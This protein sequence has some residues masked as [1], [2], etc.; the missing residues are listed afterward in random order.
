[1]QRLL[2]TLFLLASGCFYSQNKT[3]D[4]LNLVLKNSVLEDSNFVKTLNAITSHYLNSEIADAKSL[5]FQ[6]FNR[7]IKLAQKIGYNNGLAKA[8]VTIGNYYDY[9]KKQDSALYFMFKAINYYEK[10]NNEAAI[11]G[12]H[13]RIARIYFYLGNL[14]ESNKHVSLL[15]SYFQKVNKRAELGQA[16]A[17]K[18]I[19]LQ[20]M[21]D[22]VKFT[23][24][25][26]KNAISIAE[27]LRP[28]SL[29]YIYNNYGEF[30]SDKL[31]AQED[32]INYFNKA[33]AVGMKTKDSS[34][35]A[36]AD[37]CIGKVY[38]KTKKYAESKKYLLQ[39][40]MFWQRYNKVDDLLYAYQKLSDVTYESGDYKSC[41]YYTRR[42]K[43]LKDSIGQL[44]NSQNI[45]ELETKYEVEKKDKELLALREKSILAALEKEK[46]ENRTTILLIGLAV[47]I[48]FGG[49]ILYAYFNKQQANKL[50]DEEKRL[51]IKQK[52]ILQVKNQEITDS[53]TYAKRIQT[54]LMASE[55][56]I[57]KSL[58]KL[59]KEK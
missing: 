27:E 13:Q 11:T 4:S 1:M 3:L 24:T 31:D 56:Y 58:N 54:A 14:N 40:A 15:V 2:I 32:A 36:Y 51:V 47:L 49:F 42:E 29:G 34:T 57:E 50:L 41:V 18:A 16:Y 20:N 7:S 21:K 26:F 33:K 6:S 46:Q 5:G 55:N 48:G 45:N 43:T 10:D 28:E 52:E 59:N 23:N 9:F 22:S 39:A 12:L 44:S 30:L 8:H 37:F 38:L 25:Y 17:F 19:I 53:I 35:L